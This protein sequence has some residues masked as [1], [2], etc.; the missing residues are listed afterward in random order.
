MTCA[1]REQVALLATC[2]QADEEVGHAELLV[3]QLV[4]QPEAAPDS[5]HVYES[6]DHDE[7][8]EGDD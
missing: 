3:G 5:E 2:L 7:D 8:L 6:V 1:S 4:Q